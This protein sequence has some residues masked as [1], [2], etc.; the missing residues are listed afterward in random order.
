MRFECNTHRSL[1]LRLSGSA[2]KQECFWGRKQE[3]ALGPK[4]KR[5]RKDGS[6]HMGKSCG[7]REARRGAAQGQKE[8]KES[9]L[10]DGSHNSSGP[11]NDP[12]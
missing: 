1:C 6:S 11:Q 5:I 9:G 3:I 4:R 7:Q 8:A 12:E 2:K 10:G